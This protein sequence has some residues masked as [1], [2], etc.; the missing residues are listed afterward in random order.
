MT[1]VED[2]ILIAPVQFD[3]TVQTRPPIATRALTRL[4]QIREVGVLTILALGVYIS[5][6]VWM[7]YH[8]HF[9]INDALNRTADAL[10]VTMGRDPHLGAIGFYWPPLP[11]LLNLPFI[12]LLEPFRQ[13]VMAGPIETACC[14]ALTIPVIARIG[15]DIGVGRRSVF[16]VCVAFAFNPVT[17]YN[18]T[19]GMSEAAFF[20]TCS[21]SLMGFLRYIRSRSVADT[22]TFGLALGLLSLTRLEGPAIVVALIIISTFSW[23]T[24][25]DR[26]LAQQR[27]WDAVLLGLPAAFAFG[28]WMLMQWVLLKDP[29][30]FLHQ[31]GAPIPPNA[32]WLPKASSEPHA[33]YQWAGHWI[34]A[35]G[36]VVL[37]PAALVILRPRWE[38]NRGSIG[39]CAVI[40]IIAAIQIDSV[41]YHHGFGDP[42]Y[43]SVTVA[44]AAIAAMWMASRNSGTRSVAMNG[45]L[46]CLLVVNGG[47]ANWVLSSGTTTGI[48]KE[49]VFF[50]RTIASSI[51]F[52][53]RGANPHGT[54][55]CPAFPDSLAAFQR[56]GEF[57]D[58][59]LRRSDL[60]LTDNSSI[61]AADLFTRHPSQFVVRNDRDYH[62]LTANPA[63]HVTY[64]ITQADAATGTPEEGTGNIGQGYFDDGATIIG[65]SPQAWRLVG[66]FRSGVSVSKSPLWIQVYQATGAVP[67]AGINTPG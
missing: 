40:A 2:P 30:F 46:V 15:R 10:Y 56:A 38:R 17:V 58:A 52:L 57:V 29:L 39:I 21:L 45:L 11:Q 12:P 7:R 19:N 62:K 64:I 25:R 43:F 49:C 13:T 47:I 33:A 32:D 24:L 23:R 1:V 60:V 16:A 4:L 61:F 26:R 42:R 36:F 27:S 59:R 66:S 44:V 41:G 8:E 51:P 55:Y 63:G 28:G 14:M 3:W 48:E 35:L 20:L 50:Q 54:S 6:A 65:E 31:P 22:I 34:L 18:S 5:A 53:G 9:F 37:I 67:S